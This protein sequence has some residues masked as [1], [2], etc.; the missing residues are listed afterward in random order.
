MSSTLGVKR[1]R[2]LLLVACLLLG[3]FVLASIGCAVKFI[4]DYDQTI[5]NGVT[6]VQQRAEVYFAKLKGEPDTP[7]DP[8]FYNDINARMVVLKSR[9]TLLPKYDIILKQIEELQSQFANFQTLDKS[10][11]RP[12]PGP[13]VD[14]AESALTVS[15]ESILRLELALKRGDKNA[16]TNK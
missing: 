5:D 10:M 4:G 11:K 8:N 6:D 15:V 13:V 14:A 7:Y 1:R 16:P 3:I 9:A 12:F 2:R